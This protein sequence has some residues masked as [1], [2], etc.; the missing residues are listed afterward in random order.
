VRLNHLGDWGTQFGKLIVAYQRWWKESDQAAFRQ[1]LEIY[2]RF[3]EE[4]KKDPLLEEQAR[5]WFRRLEQKDPQATKIWEYFRSI[6]LVE[7]ERLYSLLGAEF[8]SFDGEAFYHDQLADVLLLLKQKGLLEQSEGAQIVR[9]DEEGLPAC[10]VVKSDGASIYATRDIAAAI[11]RSKK[12]PFSK[13]LYL[14]GQEQSLHFKQLFAVLKKMGF[15]WAKSCEH[16]SYGLVRLPGKKLSTRTGDVILA[17]DLLA[18]AHA[19]ALR[20]IEE[21]NPSLPEKSQVA[22]Q[23]GLGA[24][25]YTIFKS[26]R[27]RDVTLEWDKALSFEGE[28]GPYLQYAHVR[29]WSILR[30]AKSLSLVAPDFSLLTSDEEIRLIK[31]L[32]EFSD[33]LRLAAKQYEPAVLVRYLTDLAQAF[34]QFYRQHSV[35]SDTNFSLVSARVELVQILQ[36]VFEKGFYIIGLPAPQMM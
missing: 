27:K 4:A 28:S 21:K 12:Y 26:G 16:I 3:H 24:M 10:L 30:K 13:M 14:V 17:D 7:F 18:E 1:L 2:V 36:Q 29:C 6:S 20:V 5:D 9:L 8:D 34:N 25:V 31:M 23:V 11:Y 35:L 32:L 22:H 15:D 19:Q 33:I